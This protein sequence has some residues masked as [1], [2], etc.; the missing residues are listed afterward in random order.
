M[1]ARKVAL[2]MVVTL[3]GFFEGTITNSI[4]S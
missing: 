4:G 2:F 3:D 1:S